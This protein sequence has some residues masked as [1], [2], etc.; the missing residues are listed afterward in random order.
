V[1]FG[2]RRVIASSLLELALTCGGMKIGL[3]HGRQQPHPRAP[4]HAPACAQEFRGV[5]MTP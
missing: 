2:R 3:R 5:E 1:V 4:L